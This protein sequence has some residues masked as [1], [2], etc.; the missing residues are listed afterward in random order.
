MIWT[1][2]TSIRSAGGT[3]TN[4]CL[5]VIVFIFTFICWLYSTFFPWLL[6]VYL[7]YLLNIVLPSS[8]IIWRG[9]KLKEILR[10]SKITAEVAK[11]AK[12]KKIKKSTY[13]NSQLVKLTDGFVRIL[14]KLNIR[15]SI[16]R[17]LGNIEIS[18]YEPLLPID[19]IIFYKKRVG[20]FSLSNHFLSIIVVSSN[21]EN[22]EHL[23]K[24]VP[25]GIRKK[26]FQ[27][28]DFGCIIG[29]VHLLDEEIETAL[30]ILNYDIFYPLWNLQDEQGSSED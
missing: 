2:F 11:Q 6:P 18:L 17:N 22:I 3:R 30:N 27:N 19:S 4:N 13:P 15:Y 1:L 12:Y 20:S 28:C 26:F 14:D 25:R 8:F 24:E 16:K 10:N 7:I 29:P 9:V 5:G 21:K 23:L